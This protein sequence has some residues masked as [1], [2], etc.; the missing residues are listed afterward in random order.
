[1][2]QD[3]KSLQPDGA[4]NDTPKTF[5]VKIWMDANGN[6][7]MQEVSEDELLNGYLRQS[8]LIV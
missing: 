2:E 5:N 8:D 3:N 1:M 6:P 7:I 4:G